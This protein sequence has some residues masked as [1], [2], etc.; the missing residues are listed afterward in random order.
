MPCEKENLIFVIGAEE[1]SWRTL[2]SRMDKGTR[3]GLSS[4]KK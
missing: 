4:R 1:T 2:H 3:N